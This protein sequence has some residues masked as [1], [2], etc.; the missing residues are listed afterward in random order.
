M[1]AE[2]TFRIANN[3]DLRALA[4]LRWALKDEHGETGAADRDAFISQF[5]EICIDNGPGEFAH[6][7]AEISGAIVAVVSVQK[8]RKAP[9]PGALNGCWGYVTNV[10]ASPEARGSGIAADLL[11]RVKDWA[12]RESFEF[13][14]LWASDRAQTFY[15]RAGF[16]KPDDVLICE[17]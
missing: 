3:G 12:R 15:H 7:I 1:S 2:A 17:F 9:K 4:E 11:E 16:T 8:V 5:T 10:Y 6:W 13:L 14:I